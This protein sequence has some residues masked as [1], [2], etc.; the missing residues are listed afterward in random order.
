ML[1]AEVKE[2]VFD[3]RKSARGELEQCLKN[4]GLRWVG[5]D[6]VG[7][8]C[9][10]GPVYA[11][12]A[13]LD[14]ERLSALAN[15]RLK[16]LRDSKTLSQKQR[17]EA[18]AVVKDCA[19]EIQTAWASAREI[20]VLGI[21]QATFLAMRRALGACKNSFDVVLVDG[22]Q[23]IPGIDHPQIAV[24]KG[25]SCCHA[26]AGASIIAKE[27]RDLFMKEQSLEHPGYGF[28]DH[29]G[30]GT[31][32]HLEAITKLGPTPL[33]RM[34]FAPLKKSNHQPPLGFHAAE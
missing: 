34:N 9:L 21:L 27:T 5:V 11:S 7:R 15:D 2:R 12:C 18:V 8:G 20:E 31:K 32:A 22:N 14:Y 29:V 25:D 4:S 10:A 17:F 1:Y 6:E 13:I 16:L 33:H 3:G 24:I 23:R 28:A 30:Y 19:I 26:I